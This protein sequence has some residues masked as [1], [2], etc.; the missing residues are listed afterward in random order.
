[1]GKDHTLFALAEGSVQFRETRGGRKVISVTPPAPRANKRRRPAVGALRAD[2][3]RRFRVL[4][5]RWCTISPFRPFD[6][7]AQGS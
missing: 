2:G 3:T 7:K 6:G 5:G 4:A 1:M